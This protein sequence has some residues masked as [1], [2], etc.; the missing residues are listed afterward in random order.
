MKDIIYKNKIILF[1]FAVLVLLSPTI[2]RLKTGIIPGS[3]PYYY[4]LK[5]SLDPMLFKILPLLLGAGILLLIYL[6]LR[7]LKFTIN[8]TFILL[9]LLLFSIPFIYICNYFTPHSILLFLILLGFYL[10]QQKKPI[11]HIFGTLVFISTALFGVIAIVT[12]MFLLTY[13]LTLK[14]KKNYSAIASAAVLGY[15]FYQLIYLNPLLVPLNG[16]IS[17]YFLKD[18]ILEFGAHIGVGITMLI[19]AI[20]GFLMSWKYKFKFIILYFAGIALFLLSTKYIF[21]IIYLNI[22]IVFFA[23]HAFH[24]LAKRKW[25]IKFIGLL[26]II[27]L[28][29]S[30]LFSAVSFA[31]REAESMPNSAMLESFQAFEGGHGSI[32][33]TMPEYSFWIE[34]YTDNTP[35]TT[36]FDPKPKISEEI[37]QSKNLKQ[38]SELLD[39]YNIEYIWIDSSMKSGKVWS[40]PDQGLLFLLPS[41]THFENIYNK[42]GIEIWRFISG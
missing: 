14:K 12:P 3:L 15:I 1:V 37:F 4:M 38:T 29:C 26:A 33:L 25:D 22:L 41:K 24:A 6:N 36:I 7:K 20:F 30:F 23:S 21:F 39:K 35:F 31:D 40:S 32:I 19:L 42:G 34:Y 8:Y 13:C 18:F 16:S 11:Y 2:L 5:Y 9:F 17:S 28:I 10:F 27:A